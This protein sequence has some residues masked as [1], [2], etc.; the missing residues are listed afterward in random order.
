MS[1]PT[2]VAPPKK[3][4]APQPFDP[5]TC[6]GKFDDQ[7]KVTALVEE[8]LLKPECNPETLALFLVVFSARKQEAH[9]LTLDEKGDLVGAVGKRGAEHSYKLT[10]C[11]DEELAKN[12]LRAW[13]SFQ[14]EIIT[15]TIRKLDSACKQLGFSNCQHLRKTG[16]WLASQKETEAAKQKKLV[17]AA[18]RVSPDKQRPPSLKRRARDLFVGLSKE[19]QLEVVEKLEQVYKK[20]RQ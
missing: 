13:R 11:I 10:T 19:E 17:K 4:S 18:L 8:F 7:D 20:Q 6:P 14:P 9:S 5:A 12:F 15:S 1:S 3:R 2:E 16:A